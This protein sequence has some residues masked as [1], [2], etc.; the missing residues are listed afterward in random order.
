MQRRSCAILIG[1][2]AI[3][4]YLPVPFARAGGQASSPSQSPVHQSSNF[5]AA[6]NEIEN[7]I[8]YKWGGLSFKYP[9]NWKVEPQYYRT[10]PEE[11]A[12]KP[13]YVL[14]LTLL[15]K[16]ETQRG[17]RWIGIGGR[18]ADCDSFPSCKCFTIYIAIYSCSSDAE[19]L[20]TYDLFLRTIRNSD[21]NAAFQIAF[22]AAQDRLQP[23]THYTIRW[24]TKR[25]LRIRSVRITIQDTSSR[26]RDA[27]VLDAKN[28][29]NTGKYDWLVPEFIHSPG[30]YLLGIS[31]LKPIKAAP[32]ALSAGRIYAGSSDPF[33]IQ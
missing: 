28:V 5:P 9:A 10:P 23:N 7:W 20:H 30:P 29:P 26:R 33:Y 18:Q 19:I 8:T 1:I 2:A 14:G 3:I 17:N 24:R 21:P 16:G 25:G 15:P 11:A 31:F 4:I 6:E 32:P 12:G 22:P 27:L 13:A